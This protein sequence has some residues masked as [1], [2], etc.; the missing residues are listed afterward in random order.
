MD[1]VPVEM[2][3]A[4]RRR[5]L[6]ATASAADALRRMAEVDCGRLLVT[7]GGRVIGLITRTGIVNVV[8]I[9]AELEGEEPD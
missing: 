7:D 5:Q 1:R 8:Q 9:K 3:L 4:A 6:A 2:L